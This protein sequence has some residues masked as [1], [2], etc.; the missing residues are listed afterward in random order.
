M[1]PAISFIVP[2]VWI[3]AELLTVRIY[4]QLLTSEERSRSPNICLSI[5]VEQTKPESHVLKWPETMRQ[6]PQRRRPNAKN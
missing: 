2:R 5:L 6:K 3:R 4:N 1:V